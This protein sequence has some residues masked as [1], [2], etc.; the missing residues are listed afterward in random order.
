[1]HVSSKY[2]TMSFVFVECMERCRAGPGRTVSA[3]LLMC[4]CMKS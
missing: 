2:T 1:M 4:D 3:F